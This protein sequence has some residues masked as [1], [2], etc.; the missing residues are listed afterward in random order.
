M[1]LPE[2]LLNLGSAPQDNI[3][4]VISTS[5]Y[6]IASCNG[7]HEYARSKR[8]KEGMAQNHTNRNKEMILP[9]VCPAL[10][11]IKTIINFGYIVY[12]ANSVFIYT[13][14]PAVDQGIAI[15]KVRF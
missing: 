2:N 14:L 5:S 6:S 13:C 12:T 8:V 3:N 1:F 15:Y 11:K 10:T 4:L 9:N 7:L